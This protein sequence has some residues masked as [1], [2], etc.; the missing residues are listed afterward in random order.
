MEL[1]QLAY[2]VEVARTGNFSRAAQQRHVSQPSLSQQIRKLEEEL[3]EPL[4]Q[5]GR[6]GA[7][8]TPLGETLLPRAQL[9]LKE[10]AAARDDA[11]HFTTLAQGTV[12][13]GAIPTVAPYLLPRILRQVAAH[14]P[15][16]RVTV[17]EE[18]TG[19]LVRLLHE[20]ELDLALASPPFAE[21]DRVHFRPLLRDELLIVLPVDHPDAG[22]EALSLEALRR[23]PL[24]LMND[25]H[26][27]N[28][29]TRDVCEGRGLQPSV[30][31]HSAQLDTA[32]ALVSSG[33]GLSLVPAMAREAFAHHAVRFASVAPQ[34]VY[35]EVGL[36]WTHE[37]I[38]T[39][40]QR[41]F[42]DACREC[43]GCSPYQK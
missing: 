15:A 27:L 35:R 42:L 38:L 7:R 1:H 8:L 6:H 22:R 31:I 17:R 33:L 30:A 29:Q 28:R 5:R 11:Q 39:R 4:F 12:K 9:I 13:L 26:C 37:Q 10:V 18:T 40:A 24:V 25:T 32:V 19:S 43:F 16:L 34:P 3:G 23:A 14:F 41:A 20:G 2:F 36:I 21:S